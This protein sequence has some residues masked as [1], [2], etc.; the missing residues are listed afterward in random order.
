MACRSRSPWAGIPTT[1]TSPR[2]RFPPGRPAGSTTPALPKDQTTSI[3]KPGGSALSPLVYAGADQTQR[4]QAATTS[5]NNSA[6]GV[7]SA[8]SSGGTDFY[9]RD[10]Q[11]TLVSPRAASGSRYYYLFDGLGSVVGLVNSSGSKVNSYSYDPYGM[12]LSATG[13]VANPWRYAGGQF[14]SQTGLT[15]FGA[16]YYDPDLSRFT[17]RDPSGLD[18]PYAYAG[19]DP[20]NNVDPTGF[21]TVWTYV[22]AGIIGAIFRIGC[23]SCEI[24]G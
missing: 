9:T 4:T 24:C 11:G 15:K 8:T 2:S 6:L 22:K 16:R 21:C 19:C 18:L 20:V 3:T 7:A 5:F 12:Q 14:D 17:Q 23:L 13:T 1:R 10:N